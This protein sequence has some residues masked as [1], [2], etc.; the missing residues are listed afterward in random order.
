ML[1]SYKCPNC[2]ANLNA[3]NR[4][5]S[6]CEFCGSKIHRPKVAKSHN[7]NSK[8]Y[9]Q[10]L[11][12]LKFEKYNEL[13]QT[14]FKALLEEPNNSDLLLINAIVVHP[15][16]SIVERIDLSS[17]SDIVISLCK[18]VFLRLKFTYNY[19]L[20]LEQIRKY[21]L[22]QLKY[23][24]LSKIDIKK[25]RDSIYYLKLARM[26][27][28]ND[29]YEEKEMELKELNDKA[30]KEHIRKFKRWRS[31]YRKRV[32]WSIIWFS[33]SAFCLLLLIGGLSAF[34]MI[35]F[36]SLGSIVYL[37]RKPFMPQ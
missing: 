1:N 25:D 34:P 17:V 12:E 13:E 5:V 33:L 18:K 31:V 7:E 21:K 9:N 4:N 6:F 20:D 10:V 8:L 14:L 2:G 22:S 15:D 3:G 19:S 37:C 11:F 27:L 30:F 32:V 28:S 24:K 35:L 29:M 23:V 36:F 26:I 16:F